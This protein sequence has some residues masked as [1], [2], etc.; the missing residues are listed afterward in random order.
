M[1]SSSQCTCSLDD[2]FAGWAR[3][4][5]VLIPVVDTRSF[6][7]E[8]G[9]RGEHTRVNL[10]LWDEQLVHVVARIPR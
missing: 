10:L 9:G 1:L 6:I 3:C 2:R 4:V 8:Q 7:R 5:L